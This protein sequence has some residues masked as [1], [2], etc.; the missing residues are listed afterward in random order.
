MWSWSIFSE[1]AP[2]HALVD[3][4]TQ[5]V[6]KILVL[7]DEGILATSGNAANLM[8]EDKIYPTEVG[9]RTSQ[10]H[11]LLHSL[12]FCPWNKYR[13]LVSRHIAVYGEEIELGRLNLHLF[14]ILP[15]LR[16]NAELEYGEMIIIYKWLAK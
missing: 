16:F 11:P 10:P 13:G 15:I 7:F 9:S 4:S 14:E 1:L 6:A 5:T 12:Y 8:T 3:R 2:I